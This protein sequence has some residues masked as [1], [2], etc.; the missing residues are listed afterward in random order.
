M[1]I[2]PPHPIPASE[3]TPKE[4]WLRRRELMAGAAAGLGLAA[5]RR[6]GRAADARSGRG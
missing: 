5:S 6:P 3:I 2:K 1:L 4:H